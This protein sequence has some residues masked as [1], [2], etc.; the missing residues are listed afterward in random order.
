MLQFFLW[1]SPES[2]FDFCTPPPPGVC[3]AVLCWLRRDV[4]ITGERAK[5]EWRESEA[6]ARWGGRGNSWVTRMKLQPGQH[7]CVCK[8]GIPCVCVCVCVCT[9]ETELK[10]FWITAVK[11]G[12][13]SV[14]PHLFPFSAIALS[15]FSK[16]LAF[17]SLSSELSLSHSRTGSSLRFCLL[18]AWQPLR[19][20][21]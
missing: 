2:L 10:G 8:S 15:T 14:S 16:G 18:S 20:D 6:K 1:T 13:Q 11:P 21:L 4:A 12:R 7:F 19:T 5:E 3:R 17:C 9:L